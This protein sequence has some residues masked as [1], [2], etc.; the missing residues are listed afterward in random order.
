MRQLIISGILILLCSCSSKAGKKEDGPVNVST[1]APL[2]SK[3]ELGF[4]SCMQILKSKYPDDIF[5]TLPDSTWQFHNAYRLLARVYLPKRNLTID[6]LNF[7]AVNHI[8]APVFHLYNDTFQ[9]VLPLTDWYYFKNKSRKG[10]DTMNI[11][12]YLSF[13]TEF[14]KLANAL[15]VK[16]RDEYAKLMDDLASVIRPEDMMTTF[17]MD[18]I[19]NEGQLNVFK[20]K[21]EYHLKD[22]YGPDPSKCWDNIRQEVSIA[23][24]EYKNT[25]KAIYS[26]GLM[27]IILSGLDSRL[28]KLEVLNTSCTFY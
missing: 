8:Y 10:N 12:K 2:P 3:L 5:F 11:E 22:N 16:D 20:A 6:L 26:D 1:S 4:D 9:F 25:D 18:R 7:A 17:R 14:H 15:N 24:K 21:A 28:F 27:M 23:E 19:S 13:G